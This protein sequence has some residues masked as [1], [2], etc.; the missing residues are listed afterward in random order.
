MNVAQPFFGRA[1]GCSSGSLGELRDPIFLSKSCILTQSYLLL[2]F[3]VIA[4]VY[5]A[6]PT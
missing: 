2:G 3:L 4:T 5:V 6:P 1:F